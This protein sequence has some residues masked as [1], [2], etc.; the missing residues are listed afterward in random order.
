MI[1][2]VLEREIKPTYTEQS[3]ANTIC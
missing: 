3:I 2:I 1:I